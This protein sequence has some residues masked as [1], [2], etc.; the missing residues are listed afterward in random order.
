MTVPAGTYQSYT[1]KGIKEDVSDLIFDISPTEKPFT[2]AVR[3]VKAIQSKHEWQK[4]SLSDAS[5]TA[6]AIVEGDDATANTADP[7]V[8]LNNQL[9]TFR[10]VVAVSGKVRAQEHYGRSDEF[11]Y[12]LKKRMAELGRD[13]EAALTQNNAATAGSA[14]SAPLM[15]SFESWIASASTALGN[16]VSMGTGTAQTTPGYSSSLY[17]PVTAPTDSTV[18]GTLTEAGLKY[19][20][21]ECWN[22]GGEPDQVICGA[23]VKQKI[24][25]S[26][27]GIATRFKNVA[28]NTQ[29][30]IISG[31]DVYVSD[32]GEIA[33]VPSRFVRARTVLV[34]DTSQVAIA[35]LRGFRVEQLGKTG[36][37]SRAQIVGDYTLEMRNDLAHGKI[38]DVD[39]SL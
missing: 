15:A 4:D 2:S 28:G 23:I 10:K 18:A 25:G 39:G 20:I 11:E 7:T 21:R 3:K 27:T 19:V 24:S 9:Q 35:S 30:S 5:A 8:R 38:A 6:S 17:T 22:K 13:L 34:V 36:D 37:S 33:I 32:F 1:V 31:A 16:Y 26:F 14:S 29:A 12:Q